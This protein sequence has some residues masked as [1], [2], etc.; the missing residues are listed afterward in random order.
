MFYTPGETLMKWMTEEMER[1]VFY[2]DTKGGIWYDD[3][4]ELEYLIQGY[5]SGFLFSDK[6]HKLGILP[7]DKSYPE[8]KTMV[9]KE[10][11]EELKQEYIE[12]LKDRQ[13]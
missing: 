10:K 3:K 9:S 12:L 11:L 7:L 4:K 13:K 2:K 5:K 6:R 8:L 1:E